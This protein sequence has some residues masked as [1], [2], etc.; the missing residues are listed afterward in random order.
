MNIKS[1]YSHYKIAFEYLS[2]SVLLADERGVIQYAN[3]A[4]C[5][6]F[7]L[8][9]PDL[10]DLQANKLICE[11]KNETDLSDARV[12]LQRA[13]YWAGNVWIK[14]KDADSVLRRVQ[15]DTAYKTSK[16]QNDVLL[17][18]VRIDGKGSY[19]ENNAALQELAYHDDLTGLAN[20]A[21]FNQ[22]LKHEIG[23][24]QRQQ[25]RF[26]LLFIDLDKFKQVNDT[27]GHDAGDFLLTTIAE[28]MQK[29]LRKSD[30][31]ARI[32]GDEFVVIMNNIKDSDTVA[33]VAQKVIR[34]IQKPVTSGAHILE[35]SCS[36]GISIYPDNGETAEKIIHHADAAMYR[37]KGQGGGNYFYFS[38][39][40]NR[41]LEDTLKLENDIKDALKNQQFIPYFQPLI[42][43][44]SGS[45]VGI[46]CLA[47]WAHPTTGL[48][49]PIEFIPIAK[50]VGLMHEVLIQVLQQALRH[51]SEWNKTFQCYVPLS[52]NVTSKQFY[53]QQT[54]EQLA[55][56]LKSYDL[57]T[58]AIRIEVT[59]SALQEN[60]KVLV[61]QLT[62]VSQ[63]GFS[64]TLDDFGTGFSSLRYLQQL[65]VDTL[66][67]DRSFVRNI[68][69]NPHDKI[70]VKAIIQLAHT[71]GIE[72]VAEGVETEQQQA[73]LLD[74]NCYIMQGHL[75]SPALP[76]EEFGHYLAKSFLPI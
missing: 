34:Q 5:N 61:E 45:I 67:I 20:R 59:E 47:R 46:E 17:H 11:N 57:D 65:P 76:A 39:E 12:S 73:F 7:H 60:G 36:V 4:F 18:I 49:A 55:K 30:V 31:V 6:E 38:D 16:L 44:R 58:D 68:E 13:G 10:I 64:I 15:I 48:R 51:L 33:N 50:K 25:S 29:S 35:V 63:A 28:R 8:S 69:N 42:D 19:L 37:A 32:G 54:F 40:F 3:P 22:L 75:Y 71:L 14:R 43:H 56:L 9:L 52:I 70:I 72:A 23:Q 53:Q 41:E 2:A 27:M 24:S 21:L 74:N 1:D 26:A 62:K 66:K